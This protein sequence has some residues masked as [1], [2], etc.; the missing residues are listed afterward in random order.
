MLPIL[1]GSKALTYYGYTGKVNDIDLLVE[2]TIQHELDKID[3]H[4]KNESITNLLLFTEINN[5]P[6]LRKKINLN[7]LQVLLPNLL[8]LYAIKKSHI[9]RILPITP[10]TTQNIE[11]WRHSLETYL[12]MRNK[13]ISTTFVDPAPSVRREA[14]GHTDPYKALD[15]VFYQ[16]AGEQQD[17]EPYVE[18]LASIIFKLRFEETN[19]RVGDTVIEMNKTEEEFFKDNVKR[20]IDHDL[21]HKKM[22]MINRNEVDPIFKK[23][24]TNPNSV[25][26]N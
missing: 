15:S 8:I 6:E 7:G 18:Y 14:D 5:R 1:I 13:L 3:L 24:Q 26:L 10:S 2:S 19:Q 12:W 17:E 22:A 4:F 23:Y 16:R 21:L 20:Y 9:H 11:I 25:E